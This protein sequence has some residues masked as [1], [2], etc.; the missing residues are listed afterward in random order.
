[1]LERFLSS[2]AELRRFNRVK[3]YAVKLVEIDQ[4]TA[5]WEL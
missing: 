4:F 3:I 2:T 1:M 5:R